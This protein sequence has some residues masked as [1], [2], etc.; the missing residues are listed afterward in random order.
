M[1]DTADNRDSFNP[2]KPN[3][4]RYPYRVGL[5]NGNSIDFYAA[6]SRFDS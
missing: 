3:R 5:S 6:G 1:M 4:N 2:Y